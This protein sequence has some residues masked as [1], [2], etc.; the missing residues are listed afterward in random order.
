MPWSAPLRGAL[1][2]LLLWD[3]SGV[4]HRGYTHSLTHRVIQIQVRVKLGDQMV[5]LV[6][7]TDFSG[8]PVNYGERES[9]SL[10]VEV[11]KEKWIWGWIRYTSSVVPNAHIQHGTATSRQEFHNPN[12]L[13]LESGLMPWS[14]FHYFLAH[15]SAEYFVTKLKKKM[16]TRF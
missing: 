8:K 1:S 14:A 6:Q 5:A 10:S 9:D 2:S 15:L 16:K 4:W 12:A 3:S 7:F 13:F 11:R